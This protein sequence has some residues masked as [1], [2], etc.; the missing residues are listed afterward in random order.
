MI[1][2]SDQLDTLTNKCDNETRKAI[3]DAYCLGKEQKNN[4]LNEIYELVKSLKK[5]YENLKS[6]YNCANILLD[7]YKNKAEELEKELDKEMRKIKEVK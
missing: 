4:D 7:Y 5:D 6:L 2:I 3:Y 1:S